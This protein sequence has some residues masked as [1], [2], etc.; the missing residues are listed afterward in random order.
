MIR[1]FPSGKGF[2]DFVL[3]PRADSKGKP[4]MVIELKWNQSADTAIRQIKERRYAGNLK[5]FSGE[6][7]LVGINYDKEDRNK[8]HHC[9]IE[10]LILD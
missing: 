9:V 2:A 10:K 3:I 1:E 6:I 7:L 4:A 8:K 5:G